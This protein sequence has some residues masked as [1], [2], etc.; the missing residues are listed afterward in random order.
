M[1]ET[2]VCL[3][4]DATLRNL[5]LVAQGDII[6]LRAHCMPINQQKDELLGMVK[7]NKRLSSKSRLRKVTF[8]WL[9]LSNKT[10]Q[11]KSVR[12]GHG[13][14]EDYVPDNATK[15]Q[16]LSIAKNL[17][18]KHTPMTKFGPSSSFIF[19]LAVPPS[20]GYRWRKENY[21]ITQHYARV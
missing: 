14:K 11:Y 20:I 8:G 21:H 1:D 10:K 13:G 12:T 9:H 15:N 16:L 18:F 6:A 2:A 7:Q 17:Y 4:D 3:A 5:G 19:D